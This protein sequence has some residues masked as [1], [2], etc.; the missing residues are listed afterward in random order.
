MQ[1][2]RKLLVLGGASLAALALVYLLA[3]GTQPGLTFDRW[4]EHGLAYSGGSR[5][6]AVDSDILDSV[7]L[8]MLLSAVLVGWAAWRRRIAAAAGAALLLGLAN[9]ANYALKHGLYA[10]DPVGGEAKRMSGVPSF[11]SGH[12]TAAISAALAVV[13]LVRP[14]YR[15]PAALAGAGYA[16]AVGIAS[17]AD[18]GHY[19]SDV[20]GSYLV[21]T[22]SAAVI[23][24]VLLAVAEGAP[25]DVATRAERISSSALVAVLAPLLA[26]GAAYWVWLAL[27][28]E[29]VELYVRSSTAS[30]LA[31]AGLAALSVVLLLAYAGLY[32]TSVPRIPS[33]RHR[34]R[35]APP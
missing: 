3:L 14:A 24:A 5:L 30:V 28:R 13:L 19:P 20:A 17:V 7:G 27:G 23:G 33:L 6:D 35:D 9:A 26:A 4:A 25:R 22:A 18:G 1:R 2:S 8:A 11:P 32:S 21:T 29:S 15:I 10:L 16:A 34:S 31:T 12:S